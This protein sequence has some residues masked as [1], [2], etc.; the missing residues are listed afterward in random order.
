MQHTKEDLN[1]LDI[2][3]KEESE[4]RKIFDENH[5]KNVNFII[6]QFK[7]LP[8]ET[9]IDVD[10]SNYLSW[11]KEF[12]ISIHFSNKIYY[13]S[14]HFFSLDF[15]FSKKEGLKFET[16]CSS[17]GVEKDVCDID[18]L[19]CKANIY[20]STVDFA[21][22]LKNNSKEFE[23]LKNK[24]NHYKKAYEHW[25]SKNTELNNFQNTL[26]KKEREFKAN[27]LFK[28]LKKPFDVEK[29]IQEISDYLFDKN[30]AYESVEIVI[31]V[32]KDNFNT[33]EFRNCLLEM[34]N[35]KRFSFKINNNRASKKDIIEILKDE[36]YI[37]D[38]FNNTVKNLDF[39]D[40]NKIKYHRNEN[41]LY[42]K[43]NLLEIEEIFE[44]S[45]NILNF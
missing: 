13:W 23:I 8:E 9:K 31:L 41:Y 11:G 32:V 20:K 38:N 33:I 45:L 36:F 29:R 25:S 39:I 21:N 1:T 16:R 30:K 18:A 27:N 34:D 10:L 28:V 26:D 6:Q 12:S 14:S 43:Y 3:T 35:H 19:N 37:N 17:G 5:K 15:S 4:L 24:I 40:K 42:A 22:N 7:N 44:K 2:L